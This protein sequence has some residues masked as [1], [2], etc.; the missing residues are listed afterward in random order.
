[1]SFLENLRKD[2]MKAMK[3]KDRDKVNVVTLIMSSVALAEK[4]NKKELSDEEALVF[5]QKELKQAKDTLDTTPEDRQDIID[6]TNR[7]IEII[8]SYLPKQMS[9]EE[10]K[11]EII[12][13]I[14]EKQIAKDKKSKGILIKEVLSKFKGK[15][16]GKTVNKIIDEILQ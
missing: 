10:L 1:M 12:K 15:T 2:K 8:E 3:A 6:E 4:E 11:I 9:E 13:I 14:E 7:R 5:V 16:D